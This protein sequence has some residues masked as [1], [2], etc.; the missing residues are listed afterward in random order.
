MNTMNH[1]RKGMLAAALSLGLGALAV[2]ALAQTAAPAAKA[3]QGRY[4]HAASKEERQA[5]RAERMAKHQAELHAALKLNA[6]QEAAWTAFVNA[7][8]PAPHGARGDRAEWKSLSAPQRMEKQLAFQRERSARMEQHLAA[9]NSFYA[10]LSPEQ[11]KVFDEATAKRGGR[12]FGHHRHHGG[13][14]MQ[15]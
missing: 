14:R 9:L 6:N 15:G 5:R 10:V 2:P 4:A 12:G 8:R 1:V 13:H 7:T 11:K 3:E